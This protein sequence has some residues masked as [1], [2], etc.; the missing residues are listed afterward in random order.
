MASGAKDVNGNVMSSYSWSFTTSNSTVGDTTPGTMTIA[1]ANGTTDV[2][3]DAAISFSFSKAVD[4]LGV[5]PKTFNVTDATVGKSLGGA[6]TISSDFLT[7]TFSPTFRCGGSHQI[8]VN[9]Y[10]IVDVSGNA[11]TAPPT[12]CFTT[13]ASVN[14]VP[15]AVVSVMP[16]NNAVGIGPASPV[17]VTFSKPMDPSTLYQNIALF[18][19]SVLYSNGL[20]LSPDSTTATFNVGRP[21]YGTAYT[22]VVGPN[23]TD[24]YGNPLGSEFTSTFATVQSDNTTHPSVTAFRP[25]Q[26]ATNVDPNTPL[27]FFI[28]SPIDPTTVNGAIH[29]ALNGALVSGNVSVDSTNQIVTFTPTSALKGG[30]T[31]QV[32]FSDTASDVFGNTLYNYYTSFTVAPDLSTTP[33]SVISAYPNCCNSKTPVNTVVD[34]EFNKA[35]DF[36]TVNSGNFFV[37]DCNGSCGWYT[38]VPIPAN[39]TQAAP[40]V[41][42]LTPQSP[43]TVGSQY[44]VVLGTGILDTNGL[45][46]P[47]ATGSDFTVS[48]AAD[49]LQPS[50]AAFAPG[51]GATGIGDNAI[52]RVTFNENIDPLTINAATLTLSSGGN[53]IPYTFSYDNVSRVTITPEGALRHSAQIAFP[54]TNAITDG[55][56]NVVSPAAATFQTAAG[57]N[58][59]APHVVS[60]TIG[61]GDTNVPLNSVFTMTFDRPM[62]T[63]TFV[64]N[65]SVLLQDEYQGGYVPITLS[66][67]PDGTQLTV[68]P[69]SALAVGRSYYLQTCSALDLTGNAENCYSAY[70]TTSVV[71]QTGGPQI[72][73]SVPRDGTTGLPVNFTPEVQFDRPIAEPSAANVT[74][75]GNGAP[76]SLTPAFFN[77]DTVVR[78]Q[79]ATVLTPN[80]SYVF[81]INGITDPAGNPGSST[82]VHFTTGAGIDVGY[83]YV[84]SA[85]PLS[86][87]TTGTHPT[88]DF[89]F[90][91]PVY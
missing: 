90:N 25:G 60:S 66:F 3:V 71:T 22:V 50:V 20:S 85:N 43:L 14:N 73:Q 72:L 31:V 59:S 74:L 36:S 23:V 67:S 4:P 2:A 27:T 68:A 76:V 15:P 12:S 40:N 54:V 34:I 16:P 37:S 83:P 47:G 53:T 10:G 56:G 52:I 75:V 5:N 82:T 32:W 33:P 62:D 38:P 57:P 69:V 78:F 91:T 58:F 49:Q 18:S 11:F 26:G 61:Y 70:F 79:P 89:V 84:V 44:E 81:T 1:P 63:R 42:R 65:S 28:N 41:L 30:S 8:C 51:Q 55:V 39:I 64:V 48:S 24:V 17:T 29:V 86:G 6:I 7:A 45:A 88:I 19:G 46:Y 21:S 87:S 9:D 13:V 77:G 80:T 35:I